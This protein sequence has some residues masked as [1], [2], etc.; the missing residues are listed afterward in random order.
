MT[1]GEI[2]GMKLGDIS[3][4]QLIF[5]IIFLAVII[6]PRYSRI[7][8]RIKKI[9]FLKNTFSQREREK[10]ATQVHFDLFEK[11]IES[12]DDPF[13]SDQKWKEWLP[14]CRYSDDILREVL[15]KAQ[16]ASLEN[17]VLNIINESDEIS[18]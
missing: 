7:Y 1:L 11:I 2:L 14:I 18:V 9:F 10:W 3:R 12:A 13:M 16:L 15:P 17:I 5:L 4:E 8:Y 6:A